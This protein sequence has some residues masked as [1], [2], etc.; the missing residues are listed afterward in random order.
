MET[1]ANYVLIGLFALIGLIGSFAF[2]LWL[3]KIDV[4]RRFAYYEVTFEDVS[5]LGMA[6]AVRYNGLPIGQV[7]DL[8]LDKDNPSLVRVRL[9]VDAETPIK[10]DTIAQLNS[11]GVTGVSF[12]ALSGGSP[13]A[14]ALPSGGEIP[15]ERSAL[16]TIFEGAPAIMEEALA[17]L[18]D[19]HAVV[20]DENKE[21]VSELL[22]N[23]A[24]AS[25]KLDNTLDNFE[26]LSTDLSAA[27]REIAGFT[28][29]LGSLSDTAEVTLSEA[30]DTLVSIRG[31]ADRSQGTLESA[32]T[33][34]DTANELVQGELKEFIERGAN[35]ASALDTILETVEPSAIA[36]FDAAQGLMSERLP[37]LVD[38]IEGTARTLEAEVSSVGASATSLMQ[39]YEDVGAA[40]QDR[41]NET[42]GAIAALRTA[43]DTATTTL[44]SVTTTAD[45]ATV[46]MQEDV[47]PL[48]QE[49]TAAMSNARALTNDKL[50]VLID[51]ANAALVTIEMEARNVGDSAEEMIV[52]ATARLREVET[53]LADFRTSLDHSDTM[54]SALTT[55]AE[56]VTAL[57]EGDAA[58]FLQD[59]SA[60]ADAAR[61]ALEAINQTIDDELP[62]VMADVSAAAKG[63]NDVIALAGTEIGELGDTIDGLSAE[64]STSL[65]AATLA[66]TNANST[67]D[68]IYSAMESA[69]TTLET[70]DQTFAA[71]NE[72]LDGDVDAIVADVRR[73]VDAL[74][75]A[76][77]NV[78]DDIELASAEV[79][80][81]SKS[82]ANLV[83][84]VDD[85]VQ[86]NERQLTDFLRVGLPQI[87]HFI[88]E[89]RY[90]VGNLERLVDRVERDPA[91]F[92]LGTQGS[93]FSR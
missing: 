86:S 84:T 76:V 39:R 34:F 92:L 14:S 70:A 24:S 89:S 5:G 26:G 27:A 13:E 42:E 12:V 29:K 40:V 17:L 23:L 51:N 83:G 52:V 48:A 55:T 68:A 8:Q 3:A 15:S 20:S 58:I 82:A 91:R 9:E 7:V 80:N 88:E 44:Q 4:D 63:A 66:F 21:A 57:V 35:A 45:A 32:Q 49:A 78:T 19:V 85:I 56:S 65:N 73:A 2:L 90:L 62:S 31:A 33:A 38:Q 67:L 11:M 75:G 72:I 64:A 43:T 46:L 1:R 47:T 71:A 93:E 69:E 59:A 18:E 37:N 50:P 79:L 61:S 74:S 25:G 10:T 22:G 87:L 60:A 54:L 77:L 6:G 16:Q 28:D 53:T 36:A 41:V 81:A 30:T